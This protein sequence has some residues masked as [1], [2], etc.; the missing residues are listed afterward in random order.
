MREG[1]HVIIKMHIVFALVLLCMRFL[2]MGHVMFASVT[3]V[4]IF[5]FFFFARGVF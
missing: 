2:H 4:A 5:L 3:R 1:V